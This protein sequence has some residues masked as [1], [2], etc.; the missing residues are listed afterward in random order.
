L[1]ESLLILIDDPTKSSTYQ[2]II[3]DGLE[4]YQGDVIPEA[5]TVAILGGYFTDSFSIGGAQ[6]K[7]FQMGLAN[8]SS[9]DTLYYGV[10]GLGPSNDESPVA[11]KPNYPNF[12]D[13]LVSQSLIST[14]T[15]SLYLNDLNSTTGS[16]IFGGIDTKKFSGTLGVQTT[17]NGL[18]DM[19]GLTFVDNT[20]ITHPFT[21]STSLTAALYTSGILSY[22]P[23]GVVDSLISYFGAFDDRNNS[24]VVFVDCATRT[25][26]AGAY[27][28]FIFGI[29][30]EGGPV[31]NVPIG[32][33]ILPITSFFAFIEDTPH[34]YDISKPPF[35]DTCV[36]G[37]TGAVVEDTFFLCNTF[38]RSAYVVI[39]LDFNQTAL[40]QSV[41]GAT[42]SN[43]VELTPSMLNNGIPALSG[44][45]ASST[46]TSTSPSGSNPGTGTAGGKSGN[47]SG[48][49]IAGI[50][51]GV[52]VVLAAVGIFAF[53]CFR[54]RRAITQALGHVLEPATEAKTH[55]VPGKDHEIE[56]KEFHVVQANVIDLA[57]GDVPKADT[58]EVP[59][60]D[61]AIDHRTHQPS[62]VA[63]VTE[64]VG[65]PRELEDQAQHSREELSGSGEYPVEAPSATY[66]PDYAGA[67]DL[68]PEI[69]GEPQHNIQELLGSSQHPV[70][71]PSATYS[72]AHDEGDSYGAISSG[73]F[74]VVGVPELAAEP[75]ERISLPPPQNAI[76]LVSRSSISES[77]LPGPSNPQAGGAS[78]SD[79]RS[80]SSGP[81]KLDIL[82]NRI[83]RVRAEKER[84]SKLQELEG[85]E[86]ALQQEIMAELK[87]EHGLDGP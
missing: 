62:Q 77:L 39:D 23:A 52:L 44:V 24:G 11:N 63:V 53:I 9:N 73:Q 12:M 83:E 80:V 10:L 13:Q 79:A 70:E 58:R 27:F 30:N 87:K 72:P 76:S 67:M 33:M 57:K 49:A 14:R 78:S 29:L 86:A 51:I 61:N 4:I 35:P 34:P 8:S 48:G 71:A 60:S 31:I 19:V 25:K 47:I 18:L 69:E 2:D 75:T 3:P 28:T 56:K 7:N 41:Y 15:Y 85:M 40:A 17:P 81:S 6:L 66:S 54:R 22:A 68:P 36:L 21:N 42:E 84:L 26:Y 59:E 5:N 1:W 20:G 64:P 16:M 38:L 43:I 32:E 45:A 46:S 65:Q 74:E 50:V 37:M 55:E 82:Q